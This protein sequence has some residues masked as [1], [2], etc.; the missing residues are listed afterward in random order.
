MC[1][2]QYVGWQFLSYQISGFSL[3]QSLCFWFGYY[4]KE[5]L[6]RQ[7]LAQQFE[8]AEHKS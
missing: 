5:T 1:V 3:E 2:G 4:G 8:L 6:F 7:R